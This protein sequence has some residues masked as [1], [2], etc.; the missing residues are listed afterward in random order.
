MKVGSY[1]R[2]GKID[3]MRV[4]GNEKVKLTMV[5]TP[6]HG[7]F[8]LSSLALKKMPEELRNVGDTDGTFEEDCQWSAVVVA[9]PTLFSEDVYKA[10]KDCLMRWHPEAYERYFKT[11]LKKG[12]SLIKDEL[13]GE[14]K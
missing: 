7:G 14:N 5:S 4:Y 10:A 9:F 2:W 11:T 8:I 6:S 1:C 13:V 3:S 12:E